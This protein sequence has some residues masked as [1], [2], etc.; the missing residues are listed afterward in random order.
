MKKLLF[1]LVLVCSLT[2]QAASIEG[3]PQ[4]LLAK[5][6][7]KEEVELVRNDLSHPMRVK[8]EKVGS[9]FACFNDSLK[10]FHLIKLSLDV[11]KNGDEA[12]LLHCQKSGQFQIFGDY[13]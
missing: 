1:A 8:K 3:D 13:I 7:Q 6:L 4:S 12:A 2:S 9:F 11:F 10:R 5:Q